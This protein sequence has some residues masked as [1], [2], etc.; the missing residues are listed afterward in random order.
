LD[1]AHQEKKIVMLV[2]HQKT[3][4]FYFHEILNK[5][6]KLINIFISSEEINKIIFPCDF[7]KKIFKF[8]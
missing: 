3:S 6:G 4:D 5:N 8:Y 7:S 1:W 2:A